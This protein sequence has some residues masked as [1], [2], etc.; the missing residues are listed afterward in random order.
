LMPYVNN[1]AVKAET[2]KLAVDSFKQLEPYL[3]TYD[4]PYLH[5]ITYYIES[6][7]YTSKN[8]YLKAV[9]VC[10]KALHFLDQKPYSYHSALKAFLHQQALSFTQLRVYEEGKKAIERSAALLRPGSYDWYTNLDLYLTL[11]FHS[12]E[13]QEVYYIFNRAANHRKFKRLNPLLKEKWQISEAY[14]HFLVFVDK[15]VPIRSDERFSNFKLG[16]FLNSVPIF[17]K[18]KR[19]LNIPI[20]VIQILF[21]IA[22]RDFETAINRIEAIK[23]YCSRYLRKHQN[24]R[25]NCFIKMLLQAPISGF[26]KAGTERRAAKY[27][28]QLKS[29]PLEITN[30]AYEVE[31]IPYEDLWDIIIEHLDTRFYKA[32]K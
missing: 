4:A 32:K 26:H 3:A 9:E 15:I 24:F 16:K 7:I 28:E 12:K 14:V 13:Y 17:S 11:A 19:G 2:H 23:K 6:L 30:Q 22:K 21:T 8:D 10:E 27:L 25:S 29:A 5:Y 18:D 1:K 20:L 31:I